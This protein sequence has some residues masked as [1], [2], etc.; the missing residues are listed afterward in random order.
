MLRRVS[1]PFLPCCFHSEN[2]NDILLWV[3]SPF[4]WQHPGWISQDVPW[5]EASV[6]ISDLQ[7][8]QHTAPW[9]GSPGDTEQG[10]QW[11]Q[12]SPA[13]ASFT[14]S[15]ICRVLGAPLG[16]SASWDMPGW[17]LLSLCGLLILFSPSGLNISQ[18]V[19]ASGV[20]LP[21]THPGIWKQTSF[22][23]QLVS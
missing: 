3:R 23:N 13:L 18:E 5:Q 6:Y 8:F 20:F 17:S 12:G 10:Q 11:L 16:I 22:P 9:C 1:A 14:S 19:K 2:I 15:L 7:C 4:I 21:H